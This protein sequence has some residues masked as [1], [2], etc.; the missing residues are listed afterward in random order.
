MKAEIKVETAKMGWI[1]SGNIGCNKWLGLKVLGSR[2]GAARQAAAKEAA[3]PQVP[4]LWG[5]GW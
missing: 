4:L 1:K 3:A 5:R 2:A